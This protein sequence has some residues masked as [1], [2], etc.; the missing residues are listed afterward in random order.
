LD[1]CSFPPPTAA[2]PLAAGEE[3]EGASE[4]ARELFRWKMRRMFS[5][6]R[7]RRRFVVPSVGGKWNYLVDAIHLHEN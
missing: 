7:K 2:P 3:P 1:P 4:S 6:G 5:Q